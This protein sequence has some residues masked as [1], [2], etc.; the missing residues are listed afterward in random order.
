MHPSPW[1]HLSGAAR[2]R[3]PQPAPPQAPP[4]GFH[5]RVLS[6][7]ARTQSVTLELWWQMSVRALPVAAAVV[8]LCWLVLPAMEWEADLTELVM[9]EALP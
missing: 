3:W 2:A 7:V 4:L 8:L 6:R 9:E 1:H 5:S